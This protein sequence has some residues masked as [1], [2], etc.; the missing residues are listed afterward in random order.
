MLVNGEKTTAKRSD[1][2]RKRRSVGHDRR[3]CFQGR[4]KLELLETRW[5][6]A[7]DLLSSTSTALGAGVDIF[8]TATDTFLTNEADNAELNSTVPFLLS[9][10]E[11]E[12]G[13]VV[14]RAPTIGELVSV[15]VDSDGDEQVDSTIFDNFPDEA[16]LEAID[17]DLNPD[18]DDR[19]GKVD[20]GE[21]LQAFFFQPLADF[22]ET[23]PGSTN[24]VVNFVNGFFIFD[25]LDRTIDELDGYR[26]EFTI[27]SFSDATTSSETP[28][29][30]PTAAVM[31]EV[32]FTLIVEQILP[33]DLGIEADALRLL[34]FDNNDPAD[35]K[36]QVVDV[37][38]EL[39][40][41]FEFGVFTGGQVEPPAPGTEPE[42]DMDDFFVRE[43]DPLLVEVTSQENNLDFNL[44]IGFL[45]AQVV[46][47]N[48]DLSAVV[49]T[50]LNDPDDP[51]VLGFTD[52]QHGVETSGTVTGNNPFDAA[53]LS[54]LR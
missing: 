32:D 24:E 15:P 7:A 12:E 41:G 8:G 14:D 53:G 36:P 45:G 35:P 6:L 18:P 2:F 28:T 48:L 23:S 26:V 9:V 25:G 5:L 47:G 30:V 52:D 34:A 4:G 3:A 10:L 1:R 38:S 54:T 22:L 11:N 49:D 40:F 19:D 27:D 37:K 44:N 50:M 13:I 33:L 29:I 42:I 43:A 16:E 17:V 39:K 20:A 31:F 21:F 51:N 46:N